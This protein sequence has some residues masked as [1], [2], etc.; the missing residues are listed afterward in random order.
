MTEQFGLPYKGSKNKLARKIVDLFPNR[1]H[2]YDLFCGGCD[3]V[4]NIKE[5]LRRDLV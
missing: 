1:K 4:E 3:E 5:N 2:F